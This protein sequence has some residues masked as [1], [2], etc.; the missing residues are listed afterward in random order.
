LFFF[1]LEFRDGGSVDRLIKERG[2]TLPIEDAAAI[3][4]QALDGLDYAHRAEIPQVKMA[5]GS[6]GRGYGLVHRDLK[7]HNLFLA[8]TGKSRVVKVGDFGLA[9]AFDLAGLSGQTATGSAAGT[10]YFMP[11]QQVVNFKYAKPEVDVWAL[12]ATLYFMLTGSYPRHFAP[13]QDRWF[14]VLETNA[15]PI[16]ERNPSIPDK[17]A[18]VIDRALIDKPEI[19]FKSAA[20][21]KRALE[22]VV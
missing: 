7:P 11:R 9:K 22:G 8:G 6:F 3:A 1:T 10:P 5:G 4:L 14:A 17:L 15:V 20:E 16:R 13:D 19:P 2:G 12:A 18:K 21:L